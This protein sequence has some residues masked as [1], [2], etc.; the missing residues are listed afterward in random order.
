MEAF[1]KSNADTKYGKLQSVHKARI[2]CAM[3]K[4]NCACMM[5]DKKYGE[6]EREEK[7]EEIIIID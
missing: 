1:S 6:K 4:M 5:S 7:K 3:H 2:V